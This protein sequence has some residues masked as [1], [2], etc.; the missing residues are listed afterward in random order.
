MND[1]ILEAPFPY[2]GGK[3]RVAGEVWRRFGNVPNLI[4][5]FAG[6]LAVLLARPEPFS[7][8]ETVNDAD[9]FICLGPETLVLR[10]NLRWVSISS[11]C[12][13]DRL[14]AFDEF[15]PGEARPGLRA[16]SAYRKLRITNVLAVRRTQQPAWRLTFDDGTTVVASS[17][18]Q[19]LIGSH[20]SGG[21]GWRWGSTK[22]LIAN[23]QNQCSWVLK[24]APVIHESDT[25]DAGWLGGFFD[26]EGHLTGESGWHLG[27]SQNEGRALDTATNLLQ[28]RG[29]T[30]S[31]S[32]Q[33]RCRFLRIN[34]GRFES[35]R[36]LMLTRPERLIQKLV[37]KVTAGGVSLYG[38]DHQVVALVKKEFLGMQE[39]VSIETDT[40]TF[41]AN[42]LASH[43]CNFW[44]ALQA[45]PEQVAHHAD[46]P[47]LEPCLHAR[48][49]WLV[50][51]RESIT[52][53]VEGDPDW[54]DAKVAGWWVWGICCWIGSGWCSGNGP[55]HSVDGE[56]VKAESDGQ[57]LRRK[58]PH[59]GNAGRGVQRVRP[60]LGNA[61]MG[62]HKSQEKDGL[63]SWMQALSNRLRR[64]RVASG[65]WTRVCGDS[66]TIHNGLTAVFLD[67]PYA[68]SE[69]DSGIY[70]VE[71]AIA[72]AVRDWA[73]ERGNN[74]FYRLALCG[75]EGEYEMPEN[76][77]VFRW[78][79]RGGY[80][81]QG[82]GQGRE[83]AARE[84]IWFSP[85]CLDVTQGQLSLWE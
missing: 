43:N 56:L 41:I 1:N 45:D 49:S 17:N 3:S 78:K 70:S 65:D 28:A 13:G 50:G 55:W 19:W 52:A 44:R 67:P 31:K 30:T 83:N 76:W 72:T 61:G 75:Y 34:G 9:A 73:V 26:G 69:R 33:K 66:V 68:H 46:Y 38:R 7:G 21:R 42:G 24:V 63:L 53:Q 47:V 59:L 48:H 81:S 77:S 36:F 18:H 20:R 79:A 6:S 15:N 80:G 14:F 4:E 74:P 23:R 57:G 35:L 62:V 71:M 64:V 51:K 12:E 40:H 27:V 37:S 25:H 5:P 11:I 32:E 60:H 8:T 82:D 84:C 58:L 54:Y 2:F 16:P 85:H 39:L 29:F 22:S 10:D